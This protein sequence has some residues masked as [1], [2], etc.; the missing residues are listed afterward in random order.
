MLEYTLISSST[1]DYHEKNS[2]FHALAQVVS[3]VEQVKSILLTQIFFFK[4]QIIS[5]MHTV[6]N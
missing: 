6:E 3:S 1:G 4:V 2:S 5:V